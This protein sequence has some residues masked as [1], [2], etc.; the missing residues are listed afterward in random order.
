MSSKVNLLDTIPVHA[1]HV[2]TEQ[3]ADGCL[4]L[5]YQRFPKTWMAKL[6]SRWYSPLIH[7][8]L[9]QYGSEVWQL[10]DGKR[11]TEELIRIVSLHHPEE[12]NFPQRLAMYISQLHTDGFIT[13]Q[14]A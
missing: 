9:E 2:W 14:N 11:T 5:V 1:S 8:P 4:A 6:F 3:T 10:M 12:P 7:V 13:L